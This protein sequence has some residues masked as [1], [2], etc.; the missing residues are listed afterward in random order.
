MTDS[1]GY[2]LVCSYLIIC[3]V[4]TYMCMPIFDSPSWI[5]VCLVVAVVM[6]CA[7][8]VNDFYLQMH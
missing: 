8:V 5:E 2:V 6:C 4:H 1:F 7:C 3:D